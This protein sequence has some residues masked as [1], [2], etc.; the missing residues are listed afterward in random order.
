MKNN[1]RALTTN[2]IRKLFCI[3]TRRRNNYE[4]HIDRSN[5]KN[6]IRNL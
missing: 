4:E 5:I 3:L 2:I 1:N 6:I